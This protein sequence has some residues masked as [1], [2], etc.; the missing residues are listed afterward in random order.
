[1]E[2]PRTN[3]PLYAQRAIAVVSHPCCC[4]RLLA[5]AKVVCVLYAFD[6]DSMIDMLQASTKP[7]P[8]AQCLSTQCWPAC[9]LHLNIVCECWSYDVSGL[10][11]ALLLPALLVGSAS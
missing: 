4:T 8:P 6:A 1:M 7:V 5:N 10:S 9:T 3:F 11:T 2:I